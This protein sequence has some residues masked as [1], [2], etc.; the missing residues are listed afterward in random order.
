MSWVIQED[1]ATLHLTLTHFRQLF[2]HVERRGV[3]GR[4]FFVNMLPSLCRQKVT[5]NVIAEIWGADGWWILWPSSSEIGLRIYKWQRVHWQLERQSDILWMLKF[6]SIL[7]KLWLCEQEAFKYTL[8]YLSNFVSTYEFGVNIADIFHSQ[9]FL[10]IVTNND[11]L[12][13]R[14]HTRCLQV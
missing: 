10:S 3:I 9:Q 1:E 8:G 7:L 4:I 12:W 14:H 11:R 5:A 6:Q 2:Q 13:G